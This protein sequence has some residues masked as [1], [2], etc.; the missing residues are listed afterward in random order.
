MEYLLRSIAWDSTASFHQ[1]S[2]VKHQLPRVRLIPVPEARREHNMNRGASAASELKRLI[3]EILFAAQ[4]DPSIRTKEW[5]ASFMVCPIMSRCDVNWE[6]ITLRE[7]EKDFVQQAM[8][9]SGNIKVTSICSPPF[10]LACIPW[11]ALRRACIFGGTPN[12]RSSTGT[13]SIVELEAWAAWA[14]FTMS[15]CSKLPRQYG[16][17]LFDTLWM[18]SLQKTWPHLDKTI[19][20]ASSISIRQI[21]HSGR[22]SATSVKAPFNFASNASPCSAD[23]FMP[24]FWEFMSSQSLMATSRRSWVRSSPEQQ[25][26]QITV[27]KRTWVGLEQEEKEQIYHTLT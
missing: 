16:H 23:S 24:D 15:F 4:T 11:I 5:P 2:I 27:R 19:P 1:T 3:A 9:E 12:W 18:Q 20:S 7:N 14:I 13:V 22:L 26:T 6:K 8:R 10:S 21:P 17:L 25:A